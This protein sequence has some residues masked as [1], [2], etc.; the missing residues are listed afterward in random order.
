MGP[1]VITLMVIGMAIA[2][3]ALAVVL[4]S[5]ANTDRRIWPPQTFGPVKL[6]VGWGGAEGLLQ[7]LP[8]LLAALL[9][10]RGSACRY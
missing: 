4:W 9:L 2:G 10:A 6:A 5:I 1:L 3:S 7:D 8:D